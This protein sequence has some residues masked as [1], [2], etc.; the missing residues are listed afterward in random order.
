VT[1]STE[2]ENVKAKTPPA[3]LLG[4]TVLNSRPEIDL[5]PR[6]VTVVTNRIPPF[7]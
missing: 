5:A 2:M 6:A 4:K 7:F 1:S 3:N